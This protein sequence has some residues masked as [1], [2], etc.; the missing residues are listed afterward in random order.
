MRKFRLRRNGAD[1]ASVDMT[2]MLDIVFIML[3][4]FIV[5]SV[6]LDE[7]G[8]DFTTPSGEG[9]D[10]PGATIQIFVDAKNRI[11]VDRIPVTLKGM[12]SRVERLLADK[13]NANIM[14]MASHRATLDPVVYIKDQ[15]ELAS[16]DTVI[17]IIRE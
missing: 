14:L 10:P 17:K 1:D 3:I 12:T 5:T 6:F 15:M 9:G 4:F 2:P 16:R 7:R 11:S 13:P 8:L